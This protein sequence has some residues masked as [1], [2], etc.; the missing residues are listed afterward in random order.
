MFGET[1]IFNVKIWNHPTTIYKWMDVSSSRDESY[2]ENPENM[3]EK[4]SLEDMA[5]TSL[6]ETNTASLRLKMDGWNTIAFLLGQTAYFQFLFSLKA[7]GAG[8]SH[9]SKDDWVYP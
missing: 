7:E 9:G 1:T 2:R 4:H 6:T 3:A 5:E 8:F